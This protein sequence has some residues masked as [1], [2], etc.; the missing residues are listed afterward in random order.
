ML[1][2]YLFELNSN[3][4]FLTTYKNRSLRR[5]ILPYLDLYELNSEL[6]PLSS[7]LHFKHLQS[8]NEENNFIHISILSE[9]D[10]EEI[11]YL[12]NLPIFNDIHLI[13]ITKRNKK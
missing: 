11:D 6:I 1:L 10:T 5:T 9:D 13:Q 4:I 2:S 12:Q 3:T 8:L 7:F